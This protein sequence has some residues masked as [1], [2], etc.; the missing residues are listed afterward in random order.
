MSNPEQKNKYRLPAS[1]EKRAEYFRRINLAID[2]IEDNLHR[3]LNLEEVARAACFSP[4]HFHR[5]FGAVKG[6]RLNAFIAR[7]RVERAANLLIMNTKHSV[8]E[9]ALECGFT[10]SATFARAFKEFFGQSAS[11]WRNGGYMAFRKI[12]KVDSNIRK[13]DSKGGKEKISAFGYVGSGTSEDVQENDQPTRRNSMTEVTPEKIGVQTLDDCPVAYI[14]HTGPYQG[15]EKLFEDLF[16]KLMT[17]AGPRGLLERPDVRVFS[18]YHDNPDLTDADK[19][20]TSACISCPQNTEVDGEVGKMV[21]SGGKYVLARFTLTPDLY[22]P[23]W[24]YVYGSWLPE[25]GYQPADGPPFEWYHNDCAQ[26]PE[27]KS[28]VDICVP[29]KPL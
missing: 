4:Y 19:L 3:V 22:G 9:I 1:S 29:V 15:D 25:S 23:A 18:V 7:I 2:F 6:E 11:D 24:K 12:R 26:D 14:R 27:K 16:N 5:I 8:T 17:W 21:I 20:R 28:I 13:S 10:S